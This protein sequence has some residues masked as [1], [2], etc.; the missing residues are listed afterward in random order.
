VSIITKPI[1]GKSSNLKIKISTELLEEIDQYCKWAGFPDDPN[2]FFISA[3][4][5]VLKKDT[6]WRKVKK[7]LLCK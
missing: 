1:E 2:F 3:A 5:L 4:K 7:D 6:E